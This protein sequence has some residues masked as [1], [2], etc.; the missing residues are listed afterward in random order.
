M[1]KTALISALCFLVMTSCKQE[2]KM[3]FANYSLA[4]RGPSFDKLKTNEAG[5]IEENENDVSSAPGENN[6]D[7]TKSEATETKQ[8]GEKI[9]KTSNLDITVEDYKKSRAEITSLVKS[10][11]AFIANEN[12]QHTNYNI[13]NTIVIR[14]VNNKFDLLVDKVSNIGKELN[15]KNISSDD[16]TAQFVDIQARLK[17]KKEVEKRYLE[18]LQKAVKITDILEIEEK[19][20][21]LREEIEAQE[22]QLKYLND[23]V[24][25]STIHLTIHQDFEYQATDKPGFLNRMGNALSGGWSGFITLI[26]GIMYAWPVLI[27]LGILAYYIVKGIQKEKK[28][29]V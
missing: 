27:L 23:Q 29:Q 1:K 21:V 14:V 9:I 25:Y 28:K 11:T 6:K 26:I 4:E 22:G 24:N 13:S 7:I 10:H 16:V 5:S 12:E 15:S 8:I 17:T 2:A 20:R 19:A 3:D 18:L